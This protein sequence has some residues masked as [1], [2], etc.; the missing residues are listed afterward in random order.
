MKW[1]SLEHLG[2]QEP[3]MS[4]CWNLSMQVL[5]SLRVLG[6]A[7]GASGVDWIK[8]EEEE[9]ETSSSS[10]KQIMHSTN[11]LEHALIV[12]KCMVNEHVFV[13]LV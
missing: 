2:F 1:V 11:T 8:E 12:F 3:N 13:D 6:D 5:F 10:P 4:K 9:E 7:L